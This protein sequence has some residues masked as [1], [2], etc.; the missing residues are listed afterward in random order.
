M[1]EWFLFSVLNYFLILYLK[2]LFIYLYIVDSAEI[3]S[4]A[5]FLRKPFE[6]NFLRCFQSI[7]FLLRFSPHFKVFFFDCFLYSKFFTKALIF[8]LNNSCVIVVAMNVVF[9]RYKLMH[10][11]FSERPDTPLKR[12]VYNKCLLVFSTN[13]NP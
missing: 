4:L 6:T 13:P 9:S 1:L 7:L 8:L 3:C 2:V 12:N 10:L 11:L 5:T